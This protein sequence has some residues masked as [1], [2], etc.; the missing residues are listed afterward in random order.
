MINI[1]IYIYWSKG[2]SPLLKDLFDTPLKFDNNG[3]EGILWPILL[4]S[5]GDGLDGGLIELL[6]LSFLYNDWN[7]RVITSSKKSLNLP[8]CE[9]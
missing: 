1:F 6:R 9:K 8:I 3:F 7:L 5:A 4:V 2:F